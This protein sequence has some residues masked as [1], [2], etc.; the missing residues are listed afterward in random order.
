MVNFGASRACQTCKQRRKK[1]DESRPNCQ[2]CIK[3][4]RV[5]L[6]YQ[7]NSSVL[8]R[9]YGPPT[10]NEPPSAVMQTPT[11]PSG[12]V[13][14]EPDDEQLERDALAIFFD[15]YCVESADR[16]IS[17]G[18]LDGLKPL[19]DHA[20][21]SSDIAQA[22]KIVALATTGNRLRRLNILCK[23]KQQYGGLLH[24]FRSTLM[25][26]TESDMVET[27][28]I[29]VLLGLYEIVSSTESDPGQR[30][31]HVSGVGAILS[32]KDSPF[33]LTTGT[34]LFQLGNAFLLPESLPQPEN[35]GLLCAPS[36]NGSVLALDGI[37]INVNPIFNLANDLFVAPSCQLED[38]RT[39]RQEA[40]A[41][42]RHIS[43]WPT[44]LTGEW[45][46]HVV[47]NVSEAQLRSSHSPGWPGTV[48][49][50]FDLYV[51]AVWNTYRKTHLMILDIIVKCSNYLEPSDVC[52]E[53]HPKARQLAND[54]AASIPYHLTNDAA[55][56]LQHVQHG[57]EAQY[58]GRPVGGLLVLHPL[59]VV[60]NASV[61]SHELSTHMRNELSWIGHVMGIGQ[62]NQLASSRALLSSQHI[63]Q[64]HVL[65]WAGMLT[66][67]I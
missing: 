63:A 52:F 17:R 53:L 13:I 55:K 30:N 14:P 64:G 16:T 47:G 2:R 10:L 24:S 62:A 28:M 9:H 27:L 43:T 41:L 40:I 29:A 19:I 22:A 50:Y 12:V 59:W 67:P 6:G 36:R 61:V 48:D 32:N 20:G 65:I 49:S 4:G 54:I 46:P 31:A 34:R 18:F 23:T 37:L 35:V 21:E 3:A 42:E 1:C 57:V 56:Y 7:E 26:A 58:D 33:D 15:D 39:L 11:S 60:A 5:C 25:R 66:Q 8:F 38:V 45:A 51:A 44:R